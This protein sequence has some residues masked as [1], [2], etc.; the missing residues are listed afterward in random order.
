MT[1][2]RQKC[3]KKLPFGKKRTIYDDME[4]NMTENEKK[5]PEDLQKIITGLRL[6]SP[7]VVS[8]DLKGRQ[9]PDDF[10]TKLA[11]VLPNN[12][13]CQY[14]N[15]RGCGIS[16]EAMKPLALVLHTGRHN[17]TLIDIRD[18][19]FDSNLSAWV[20]KIPPH[21]VSYHDVKYRLTDEECRRYGI[22]R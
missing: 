1:K 13:R 20:D 6:D 16:Y 8:V 2:N 4:V 7:Q 12:S 21:R 17:L 10:V 19:N 22:C 9:L 15:L 14:L 5:L 18:N 11:D 3:N